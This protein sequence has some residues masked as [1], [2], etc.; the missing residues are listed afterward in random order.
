MLIVVEVFVGVT[1][2]VLFDLLLL[3]Y[4]FTMVVVAV[5]FLW[6]L[7]VILLCCFVNVK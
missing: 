6:L 2:Y 7:S 5:L 3:M 1:C 4:G